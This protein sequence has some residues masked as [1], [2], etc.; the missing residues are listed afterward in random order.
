GQDGDP[1]V[2]VLIRGAASSRAI[3]RRRFPE[4]RLTVRPSTAQPPAD[5]SDR[6][7]A[8]AGRSLRLGRDCSLLEYC[9]VPQE[10][11]YDA[12]HLGGK[13]DDDGVRMCS[14]EKTAQP[15]T[16]PSVATAQCR[17]G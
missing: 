10:R 8:A 16:K 1:R 2:P 13:R 11:P 3:F 12:S 9:I 17:Q 15:L 7:P 4:H 5:I 14:R 6:P